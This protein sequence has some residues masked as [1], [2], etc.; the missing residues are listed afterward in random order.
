MTMEPTDDDGRYAATLDFPAAGDWNVRF[1][2]VTPPGT[3]EITQSIPAT[4]DVAAPTTATTTSQDTPT[5]NDTTASAVAA[6][7]ETAPAPQNDAEQRPTSNTSAALFFFIV[8]AIIFGAC[9]LA[10][11]SRGERS[12]RQPPSGP[13]PRDRAATAATGDSAGHAHDASDTAEAT[14][15]DAAN[16]GDPAADAAAG[17][18]TKDTPA[19]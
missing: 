9:L 10:Y 5:T 12:A 15:T 7:P 2:V 3:L 1:T 19:E 18:D 4:D 13:R 16:E 6:E 11:R 14:S 17:V 8:A